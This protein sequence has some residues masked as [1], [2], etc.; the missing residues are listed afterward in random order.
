MSNY[1][2]NNRGVLNIV[3]HLLYQ[4]RQQKAAGSKSSSQRADVGLDNTK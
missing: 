1:I 4:R 2:V 3:I